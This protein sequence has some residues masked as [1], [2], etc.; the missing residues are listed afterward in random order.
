MRGRELAKMEL[1][2]RILIP[3]LLPEFLSN[4]IPGTS[5]CNRASI[6]VEVDLLIRSLSTFENDPVARSLDTV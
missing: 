3:V 1:I 5:D 6:P 2:P 4:S